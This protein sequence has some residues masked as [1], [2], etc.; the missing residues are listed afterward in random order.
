[1]VNILELTA[2]QDDE[3]ELLNGTRPT[4]SYTLDH[5]ATLHVH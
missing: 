4:A 1:M 3:R 5:T 2:V